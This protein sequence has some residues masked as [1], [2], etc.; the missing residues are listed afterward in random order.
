MKVIVVPKR[1]KWAIALLSISIP[2]VAVH[3]ALVA[4]A[5]WW[6]LPTQSIQ[7]WTSVVALFAFPFA[8]WIAS[9]RRWAVSGLAAFAVV[10]C[11]FSAFL[12]LRAHS[13]WQGLFTLGLVF[14][15]IGLIAW[16][17]HELG[18]S[19]MD[20]R[21]RWFQGLPRPIQGVTCVLSTEAT[22]QN[23]TAKN[24]RVS[25]VDR[26][27]VFVFLPRQASQAGNELGRIRTRAKDRIRVSLFFKNKEFTSQ[28]APVVVLESGAG[29][30]MRFVGLGPDH[31][32]RLGDFVESLE[33]EGL[34]SGEFA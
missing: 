10:W 12:A 3:T 1:L 5:P 25:R 19:Y 26:D 18:R 16:I 7:I 34:G 33:A 30:G 24:F 17:R 9:G 28:A 31:G 21:M 22:G 32:K 15:W 13:F 14:Y 8:A 6:N 4:Q 27:G 20:P 2:L 11:A 23:V 29:I